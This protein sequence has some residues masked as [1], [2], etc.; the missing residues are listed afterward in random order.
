VVGNG[1]ITGNL[2]LGITPTQKLHV[3]GNG[4]FTGR[5]GIATT[6]PAFALDA[7]GTSVFGQFKSTG[8]YAGVILDKSAANQN[9]YVIYRTAGVDKWT[10]G[11]FGSDNFRLHNWTIGSTALTIDITNNNVGVGAIDAGAKLN[12]VGST[13]TGNGI[14][15]SGYSTGLSANSTYTYGNGVAATT[16]QGYAV[17]GTSNYLGVYG[18][19]AAGSY[20]TYGYSNYIGAYGSGSTYG[21]YGYSYS[22][23]AGVY[24][25]SSTSNGVVGTSVDN[26]G[27]YFTSTNSYA[28]VAST[29]NNYYAGVFYGHVYA[30]QGFVTSDKNLKKDVQD[31]SDAMSI[32]NKLKPAN[33]LFKDDAKYASLHLPT[34]RHYGLLAQD[35]EQVLPNLVS[36]APHQLIITQ[37]PAAVVTPTADGKPQPIAAAT[38]E[39]KETI[40]IKAVN[41]VELIPIMVKGMQEQ[42]AEIANLKSEINELKALILKNATGSTASVLAGYLKQNIPNP[43]TGNTVIKYF[44]PNDAKSAQIVVTDMKGSVL[45]TYTIT[46]GEGQLTIRTGELPTGTYNYTL[47]VNNSKIDTKQMIIAR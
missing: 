26:Y 32:I 16:D 21:V 7:R 39:T 37:N 17:F 9:A 20:G 4:V 36:E 5:I 15:V 43:P 30:S 23:T 11:T 12:V 40:N 33:Y 34:G 14:N 42:E 28:L 47:Y 8:G 29:T 38:K 19:A 6:A 31:F 45:K 18:Y 25:Y 24:G 46:S 27:G 35:L 1:V 2:G 3:S 44:A 22:G 10:A 13:T 41:Y